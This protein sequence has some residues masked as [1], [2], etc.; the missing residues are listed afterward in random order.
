MY[1]C[2]LKDASIFLVDDEVFNIRLLRSILNSEGYLNIRSAGN[3]AD[4]M[5]MIEDEPPDLILLDVMMPGMDGFEV[6]RK[7]KSDPHL[8]FIP[9]IIV[10]ALD[11]VD[12]YVHAID[13]G[14]DDFITKPVNATVLKARVR[15]Y[16]RNKKLNDEVLRLNQLKKDLTR[17]IVHDLRSPMSAIIGYIDLLKHTAEMSSKTEGMVDTL[18]NAAQDASM[19]IDNLLGVEKLESGT[20]KINPRDTNLAELIN[21]EIELYNAE[22]L[23]HNITVR[24]EVSNELVC[25]CDH[26]LIKRVIQNLLGNAIKFSPDG[27]EILIGWKKLNNSIMFGI[28]NHGPVIPPEDASKIFSKFAQIDDRP[29]IARR[30]VGLGLTFCKMAID[31]HNGKIS[32]ISPPEGWE[33]G[34]RFE[35]SLPLNA[36]PH[37]NKQVLQV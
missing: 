6:C 36:V 18:M 10:T 9:V 27:G 32:I 24:S 20:L 7:I 16:L 22:L 5:K 1:N 19:L 8:R 21:H 13:E 29:E 25:Q 30:G 35:V 17:M 26:D 34:A 28:C 23:K 31:A 37:N 15:G 14:A 11:D 2:D 4:A 33:D 3:G 12:D